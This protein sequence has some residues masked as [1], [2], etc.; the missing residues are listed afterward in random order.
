MLL[1]LEAIA[2]ELKYKVRQNAESTAA[3]AG[4]ALRRSKTEGPLR[5]VLRLPPPESDQAAETYRSAITAPISLA[6]VQAK[7]E[8]NAYNRGHELGNQ[9]C[10]TGLGCCYADGNGVEQDY[11]AAVQFYTISA[12]RGSLYACLK[13]AKFFAFGRG[14]MKN[15][16]LADYWFRVMEKIATKNDEGLMR[17]LAPWR[18]EVKAMLEDESRA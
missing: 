15:A 10:T 4:S 12:E 3:S 5:G 8:A 17:E 11:A 1:C 18:N 16:R 13:L 6:E 2:D 9:M 7:V 14:D